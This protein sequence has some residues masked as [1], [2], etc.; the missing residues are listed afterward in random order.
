MQEA[1][2]ATLLAIAKEHLEGEDAARGRN[3]HGQ[4]DDDGDGGDDLDEFELWRIMKE[5]VKM[6]RDEMDNSASISIGD[7]NAQAKPTPP[8]IPARPVGPQISWTREAPVPIRSRRLHNLQSPGAS[9]VRGNRRLSQTAQPGW[10][11]PAF[12]RAEEGVTHGLCAG[13]RVPELEKRS[14]ERA[15]TAPDVI[16]GTWKRTEWNTASFQW[17]M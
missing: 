1:F 9:H 4:H 3:Q 14:H 5:Q 7:K 16:L 12:R 2:I 11:V 13:N 15:E 17:T 8:S 6:L 10:S